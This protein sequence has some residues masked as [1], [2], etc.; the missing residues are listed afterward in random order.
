MDMQWDQFKSDK[1]YKQAF[2][3][4]LATTF[5]MLL[6]TNKEAA[7]SPWAAGIMYVV[8]Q[9]AVKSFDDSVVG[10]VEKFHK[11]FLW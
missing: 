4:F 5:W 10:V 3:E 8:I 7:D 11:L 9:M 2:S 6:S 1:F